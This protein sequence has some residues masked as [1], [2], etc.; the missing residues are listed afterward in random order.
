MATL[1]E[2]RQELAEIS[3]ALRDQVQAGAEY[4]LSDRRFRGV[5]YSALQKRKREVE[6]AIAFASG[7]PVVGTGYT[8]IH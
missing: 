5:D 3:Q 1:S 8:V 2:L 6:R 4:G 7:G